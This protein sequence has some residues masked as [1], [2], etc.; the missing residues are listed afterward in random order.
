MSNLEESPSGATSKTKQHTS[1]DCMT[2]E[3]SPDEVLICPRCGGAFSAV[4]DGRLTRFALSR[5]GGE[6]PIYVCSACGSDEAAVDRFAHYLQEA[7]TLTM[8]KAV[9]EFGGPCQPTTEGFIKAVQEDLDE[10]LLI[11]VVVRENIYRL[12]GHPL[13]MPID[14]DDPG[15]SS[16]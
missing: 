9:A 1:N 16:G 5:R 13:R 6:P 2:S 3:V 15:G 12:G 4:V 10:L 11:Q 14:I 7:L 8:F